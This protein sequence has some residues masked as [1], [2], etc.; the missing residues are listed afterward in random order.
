MTAIISLFVVVLTISFVCSLLEATFLSISPAYVALLVKENPRTGRLLERLKDNM[1]RPLSAILTLNTISHTAG[2]AAIGA[3]VQEQFGSA[4]ITMFSIILTLGILI[5]SEILPKMLGT[6]YWK[7]LAPFTT[8]F[9][10][11]IIFCLYP[12]VWLMEIGS[13]LF[14]RA[15]SDDDEPEITRE[16]VIATAELGADEGSLHLKETKI[17]KNLLMLDNIYV[18]DIMT[19]RSVIFA[20]DGSSTVEEVFEKYKPIR[21]SRIPVFE[22]SLDNIVGLVFRHKVQDTLSNDLHEVKIKELMHPILTVPERMTAGAALDFF[23]KRKEHLAL[24][25]DEYGIVTGLVTLEDTVETLLGVEIVDELDS[26]PDM[27]QYALEQWQM[28]KNQLRKT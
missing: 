15:E 2:S 5:F 17:I 25:V 16:E 24:A 18:S 7:E 23:V 6:A 1:N 3:M 14:K 13:N 12:I 28:R 21:F 22:G 11:S 26:V 19:P 4:S 9:I 27:R 20:L 10:Q 8:Y